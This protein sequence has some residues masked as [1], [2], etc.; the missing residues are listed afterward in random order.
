MND[1]A[2]STGTKQHISIFVKNGD[3]APD[4]S[5]NFSQTFMPDTVTNSNINLRKS[6]GEEDTVAQLE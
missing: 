2:A 1:Y 4:E 6:Q 3:L 5:R